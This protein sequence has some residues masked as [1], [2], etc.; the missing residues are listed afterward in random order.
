MTSST[1]SCLVGPRR[2]MGRGQERNI[3]HCFFQWQL[4]TD[5]KQSSDAVPAALSR[6]MARAYIM[7]VYSYVESILCRAHLWFHNTSSSN[8]CTVDECSFRHISVSA[9][10]FRQWIFSPYVCHFM[11]T[12]SCA[13][14]SFSSDFLE[15]LDEGSFFTTSPAVTP[16]SCLLLHSLRSL[17]TSQILPLLLKRHPILWYIPLRHPLKSLDPLFYRLLLRRKFFCWLLQI[18]SRVLATNNWTAL[19]RANMRQFRSNCMIMS[20]AMHDCQGGWIASTSTSSCWDNYLTP[21]HLECLSTIKAANSAT[22]VCP[23]TQVLSARSLYNI[24]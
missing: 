2:H 23:V 16:P 5:G 18:R 3:H 6:S 1:R 13:P 15:T 7:I 22:V 17:P 19:F 9:W 4:K 20:R 21:I 12:L 10:N 24:C 8:H 11:V 14:L